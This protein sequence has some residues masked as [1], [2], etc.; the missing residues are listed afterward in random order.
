MTP[1][2][3]LEKLREYGFHIWNGLGDTCSETDE[4]AEKEAA[5]E[6]YNKLILAIRVGKK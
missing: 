5:Q 4:K 2:E 6:I 1:E 3:F